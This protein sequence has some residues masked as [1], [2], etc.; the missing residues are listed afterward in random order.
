MI[1][2]EPSPVLALRGIR[3]AVPGVIAL[4][5]VDLDLWPGEVHVPSQGG[6]GSCSR[7]V[8]R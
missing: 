7:P 6:S 4:D 1:A 8:M 3:K 5:G 2:P